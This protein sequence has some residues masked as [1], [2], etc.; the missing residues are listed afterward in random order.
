MADSYTFANVA[1][2]MAILRHSDPNSAPVLPY[3]PEDLA[4]FKAGKEAGYRSVNWFD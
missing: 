3:S 2:D 4:K 1:N